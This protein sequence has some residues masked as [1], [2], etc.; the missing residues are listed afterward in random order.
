SLL[1]AIGVPARDRAAARR[2]RVVPILH[3]VLLGH[4][5]RAGIADVVIAQ[6]VLDLGRRV[7]VDQEPTPDLGLVRAP[8]MPGGQ[9]ARLAR[10]ERG[11]REHLAD[12]RDH[13]APLAALPP[14]RLLTFAEIV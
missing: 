2:M 8:R 11:V 9:G 6:E 7:L 3:V 4:A 14:P 1:I 10:E 12:E 13:P 5:T